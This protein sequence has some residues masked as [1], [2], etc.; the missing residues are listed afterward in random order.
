M[1]YIPWYVDNE[2]QLNY[3]QHLLIVYHCASV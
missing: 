2:Q 1:K 3:Q